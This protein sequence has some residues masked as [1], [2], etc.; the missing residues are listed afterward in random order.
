MA[1]KVGIG[2][3]PNS[4][5]SFSRR[6][7]PDG[8]NVFVLMPSVKATHLKTSKGTPVKSFN[9]KTKNFPDVNAAVKAMASHGVSNVQHLVSFWNQKL[10][11]GSFLPENLLGNVQQVRKLESLP[12]W[13]EFVS[14]HLPWIHTVIIPDFTH[15]ISYVLSTQEFIERK[16]GGEAYQRFWELAATALR[17]FIISIDN[18]RQDLVV[19]TE[20]HAEFDETLPGFD[21]FVPGGKMLTEKFKVPSYYD[22]LLFTDVKMPEDEDKEP[23]YRFVTKPTRRYPYARA[24]NLFE[25]TYIP[26]DLQ[27]VLTKV[28]EYLGLEWVPPT[29]PEK[30]EKKEAATTV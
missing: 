27:T 24:M 3:L 15:F 9:V 17:N 20:Y 22:V 8:E 5:K 10:P 6:S 4:G 25:E 28:R 2:G 16:A 12:I 1:S 26:N 7:I 21:I 30:K 13:L 14:K 11:E 29:F 23:E 18:Y 19:V